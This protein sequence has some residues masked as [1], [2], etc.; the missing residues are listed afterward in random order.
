MKTVALK[1]RDPE[2]SDKEQ[3]RAPCAIYNVGPSGGS[4][5]WGCGMMWHVSGG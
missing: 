1:G 5:R 2:C 4:V 3:T